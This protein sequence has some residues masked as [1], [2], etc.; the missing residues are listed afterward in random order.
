MKKIFVTGGSGYIGSHA[1]HTLIEKGFDVIVLDDLSNSKEKY[2]PRGIKF[3]QGNILDENLIKKIFSENK[4]DAV[5]HFAGKISVFESTQNPSLYHN[6]NVN[7]TKIILRE[8]QKNNVNYIVFSS[9]AAVYGN[10]LIQPI[11]ED[12]E[13]KPIN[14]YGE[15][16][17]EAEELIKSSNLNYIIF[18]YF[19]V[20]GVNLK[21]K[22]KYDPSNKAAHLIPIINEAALGIRKE[23]AIFGSDYKTKD[24]TAVRD[25]IHVQ[26]LVNAHILGLE[27]L[28]K[29]KESLVLNLSSN[30]GFTVMEIFEAAKKVL[31]LDIPLKISARREGDPEILIASNKLVKKILKWNPE[32]SIED[33]IVSDYESKR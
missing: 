6:V 23:F 3:Y 5:M 20:A 10:S 8:M 33:M 29:T 1:V 2:I 15:S 32:Y 19:N 16:K 9:T 31:N 14:P 4:I 28:L 12:I 11:T 26:D 25:F 27:H 30:N 7:G 22:L 17:L 18:R 13:T 21:Y 24:G